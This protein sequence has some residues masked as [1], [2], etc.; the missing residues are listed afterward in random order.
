MDGIK[1]PGVVGQYTPDTL[2]QDQPT[3]TTSPEGEIGYSPNL[4]G[5]V[6]KEQKSNEPKILFFDIESTG[7]NATF[8]TI[9]CIGY[10]WLGQPKVHCP[11]I[12]DCSNNGM[13]DDKGL[14]KR[15][16]EVY[17]EC[18]YAVGHYAGN[19]RFD[20]PMINSKLLKHGLM[21]LAPAPIVDTW[22]V[23]FDTFKLHNNR[24]VTVQQF[25]G[26]KEEKTPITFD[27]WLR[28]AHGDRKSLKQIVHHCKQDVLVLEEVF[29]KIRPWIKNEPARQLFVKTPLENC[30]SC[31]SSKMQR[32]GFQAAKTRRYP[33]Y[34]CQS[35]GKWHR[36]SSADPI[37]ASL[38]AG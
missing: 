13:L 31:G 2:A 27:D 16:S 26:C 28:A 25:L 14:V 8:G 34:Q 23:M 10:K 33:R 7:L 11:T 24:L 29:L 3:V 15:F 5:S 9:L 36:G 19:R 4:G 12:L 37:K 17:A 38:T 21:P 32:R 22:R 30:T 20:A 18:D 1:E 6:A 35:C